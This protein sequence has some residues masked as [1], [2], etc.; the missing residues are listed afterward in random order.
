MNTGT[1]IDAVRACLQAVKPDTDIDGIGNDTAL[2]ENRVA[3]HTA[4]RRDWAAFREITSFDVLDL[5]LRLEQVRGRG[6]ER[7]QLAPGSFRDIRTIARV[8]LAT[9]D[10]R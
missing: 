4:L 8:F 10:P 9:E 2:L 7:R 3:L 6:I 5:I 1:A